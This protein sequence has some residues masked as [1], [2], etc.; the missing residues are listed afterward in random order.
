NNK[1]KSLISLVIANTSTTKG[2]DIFEKIQLKRNKQSSFVTVEFTIGI[3]IA[4]A[5][6]ILSGLFLAFN[7]L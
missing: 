7:K 6:I 2:V 4:L 3:G 1:N 5:S